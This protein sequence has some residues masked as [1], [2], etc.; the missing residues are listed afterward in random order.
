M[1]RVPR[2]PPREEEAPRRPR[3]ECGEGEAEE[4]AHGEEA[5]PAAAAL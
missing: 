3:K 2:R 1:L 4:E 5:P